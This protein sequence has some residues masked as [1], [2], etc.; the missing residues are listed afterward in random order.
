[1][2]EQLLYYLTVKTAIVRS[3]T[4]CGYR[5]TYA[6][7]ERIILELENEKIANHITS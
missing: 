7:L 1:M 3:I 4:V 5:E 6:N 2:N